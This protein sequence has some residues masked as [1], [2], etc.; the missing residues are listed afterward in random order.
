MAS[1]LVTLGEQP[2]Q[3]NYV[4]A[5]VFLESFCQHRH[6]LGLAASVLS[7]CPIEDVGFVADNPDVRRKLKLQGFFFVE[8]RDLLEFVELAVLNSRP[9]ASSGSR[10]W[11]ESSGHLIMG[12][13]S[14]THLDDPSCHVAWRRDRR[15]GWYH[16]LPR[17]DAAHGGSGSSADSNILKTF[18]KRA[19]NDPDRLADKQ[20]A[21]FLATEVGR[22][23][24]KLMMRDEQDLQISSTLVEIGMDSLMAIELRRWWKQAFGTEVSVLEIMGSGTLEELGKVAAEGLKKKFVAVSN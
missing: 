9:P 18:L 14:P 2:G 5:N 12:L 4:A 3:A 20:S 24:F 7:I 23:V 16:N 1:S 13:H 10:A 19:A 21:E 11:W 17:D 15:M 8:E 6:N 22:R